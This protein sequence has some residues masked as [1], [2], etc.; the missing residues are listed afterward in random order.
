[1]TLNS[2]IA[3]I[4]AGKI[5]QTLIKGLIETGVAKPEQIMATTAHYETLASVTDKFAVK[6]TIVNGDAVKFADFILI[7]VKPQVIEEALVEIKDEITEKKVVITTVASVPTSFIEAKLEKPVPVIRTMP[8][9]PCLVGKGMTVLTPGRY[10]EKK[11]LDQAKIIFDTLGRTLI[12][13]EKHMDSVTGLSG[14]GPA[15]MYMIV[16]ALADGGV[17]SG[18]PRNV[19]TV[20]AAQTMMG[21]GAMILQTGEHPALLKDTVTT[22]AGCT[23][24]G[25][26]ELEE[27][28]LRVTLIKAVVRASKTAAGLFRH[29]YHAANCNNENMRKTRRS[30]NKH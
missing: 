1:M 24:D 25:I 17:K 27:G 13:D 6:T 5:G 7:C 22:P 3:V 2:N 23:I 16:E 29:R 10:V 12:L 18:L 26:L 9:T 21:A 30:R 11:H 19:A 15:F 28:G 8:N 14:S 4:G 20:L